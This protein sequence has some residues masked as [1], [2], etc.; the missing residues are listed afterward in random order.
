MRQY[1][2]DQWAFLDKIHILEGPWKADTGKANRFQ[3]RMEFTFLREATLKFVHREPE[4]NHMHIDV[5]MF[6]S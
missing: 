6:V 4:K 2:C 1:F 5:I 3:Y